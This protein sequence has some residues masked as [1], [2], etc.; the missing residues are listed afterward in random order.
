MRTKSEDAAGYRKDRLLHERVH[1]PYKSRRKPREPSVCPKCNAVF[2]KGR[3]QWADAWPLDSHKEICPACQR[4]ADGYPAGELTITGAFLAAHKTEILNLARHQE[5]EENAAHP[6]HRIMKIAE[7]PA[8]L[9][10]HTT[11]L[12]LPRRI[13]ETLHRA[14][15]G[16]LDV[17]YDDKGCFVRVNWNREQ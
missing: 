13:G 14:Y 12:H 11:D 3:W 15:A 1:D 5:V 9:V 17:H 7:H 2:R 8:A 6:L 4:T 16:D 10:I